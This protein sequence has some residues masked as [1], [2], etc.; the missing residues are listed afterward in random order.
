MESLIT[1]ITFL[2]AWI[3]ISGIFNNIIISSNKKIISSKKNIS[4]SLSLGFIFV[5]ASLGGL[6]ILMHYLKIGVKY[7]NLIIIIPIIIFLLNRKNI[8]NFYKFIKSE[9]NKIFIDICKYDLK[10]TPLL[11]SLIFIIIVQCI[12]LFIRYLLPVTHGDALGQYFYDSLQ[13]SRLKD[14]SLNEYYQMGFSLRTDSLASFFDAFIIQLTD[15]WVI[16]RTIRLISLFLIISSAIELTFNIGNINFKRSIL[17]I[18]IILTTPDVWDLALSGKHDIYV[19]LFE[20]TCIYSIFQALI[21]ENKLSKL[22]FSSIAL[23]ISISSVSIRLSSLTLFLI[24]S[25]FFIYNF[26]NSK[27]YLYYKKINLRSIIIISFSVF[28]IVSVLIIGIMNYQYFSNPFCC[29]LSP[30]K[31]L[32]SIFPEAITPIYFNYEVFKANYVLNNIPNLLKPI[33]TILYATL[34]LEP[35]RYILNKLQDISYIPIMFTKTLNFIGPKHLMVSMLSLSPF[36]LIP[37]FSLNLSKRNI[38]QFFLI[39]LIFWIFLWSLSI[40]YTRVAIACSISLVVFALSEPINNL[41]KL[42]NNKFF[43]ISKN[44][45]IIYGVLTI[46]LFSIWSISTLWDLPLTKLVSADYDRKI[47]TREYI[48]KTNLISGDKTQ[49]P[50][51]KFEKEWENIVINNKESYLFLIDSPTSFAYFMNE[52]LITPSKYR[53]IKNIKDKALCFKVDANQTV[54]KIRCEQ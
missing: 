15:S 11:T 38:K 34:G 4:L 44:L 7:N 40:P 18:A 9:I 54:I 1:V 43:S 27:T 25:L 50:S 6:N 52:G 29:R 13:I 35:I 33:I 53:L 3:S 14:I 32:K 22:I 45:I 21:N 28:L 49:I 42:S 48:K 30:P 16:V 19:A 8:I 37:F 47:L 46:Y 31:F 2:S 41:S 24:S 23:F 17:L 39:I 12:C 26:F 36:T 5:F 51:Q 10:K 20:L